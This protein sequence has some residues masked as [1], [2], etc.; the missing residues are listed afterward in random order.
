MSLSEVDLAA[1]QRRA[2]RQ[3]RTRVG[4]DLMALLAEVQRLRAGIEAALM[5]TADDYTHERLRS[6][7]NPTGGETDGR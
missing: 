7:L 3:D 2:M 5:T 6:L 4:P 1:I